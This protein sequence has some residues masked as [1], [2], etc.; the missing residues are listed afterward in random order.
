VA[1]SSRRTGIAAVLPLLDSIA[2]SDIRL[3]RAIEKFDPERRC[4]FSTC[5]KPLGTANSLDR[6]FKHRHLPAS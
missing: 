1:R 4:R 2:T 6:D 5:A 3:L